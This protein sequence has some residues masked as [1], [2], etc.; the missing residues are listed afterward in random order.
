MVSRSCG[1]GGK[2]NAIP[3]HSQALAAGVE[4]VGLPAHAPF[5]A[6]LHRRRAKQG[7]EPDALW[8]QKSRKFVW[9]DI[10]HPN[11]GPSVG[12][13]CII[14]GLPAA[15]LPRFFRMFQAFNSVLG[16][17]ER[18]DDWWVRSNRTSCEGR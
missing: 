7:D 9:L 8:W 4:V 16:E 10:L 6:F 11:C 17:S 12:A 1:I 3:V 18:T 5:A 2:I 15:T 13:Y 14:I